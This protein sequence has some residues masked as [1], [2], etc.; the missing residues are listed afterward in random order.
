MGTMFAP[1]TLLSGVLYP[2]M[3][4]PLA[5]RTFLQL[6]Y[7][8]KSP[9]VWES[10]CLLH[11]TNLTQKLLASSWHCNKLCCRIQFNRCEIYHTQHGFVISDKE[12]NRD[13]ISYSR[14]ISLSNLTERNIKSPKGPFIIAIYWYCPLSFIVHTFVRSILVENRQRRSTWPAAGNTVFYCTIHRSP[15]V[16]FTHILIMTLIRSYTQ[17]F[18]VMVCNCSPSPKFQRQQRF[19]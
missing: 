11:N 15:W 14:W 5:R 2:N 9:A 16:Y 10:W 7:G 19:N 17:S 13:L 18:R 6:P 3:S 12:I 8:S 4:N 1:W